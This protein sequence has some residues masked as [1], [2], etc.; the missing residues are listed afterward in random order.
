MRKYYNL[1]HNLTPP[2]INPNGPV[3]LIICGAFKRLASNVSLMI[4]ASKKGTRNKIIQ[5]SHATPGLLGGIKLD[6]NSDTINANLVSQCTYYT[7][8]KAT[9]NLV[10]KEVTQAGV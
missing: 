1:L 8:L 7:D 10:Y 6:P 5:E 3:K 9:A 4:E 2:E